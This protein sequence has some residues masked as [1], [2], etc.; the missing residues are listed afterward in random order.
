MNKKE[1]DAFRDAWF[2]FEEIDDIKQW[3]LDMENWSVSNSDVVFKRLQ[4]KIVSNNMVVNNY[5]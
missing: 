3:I 4:E 1:I 2:S 5:V